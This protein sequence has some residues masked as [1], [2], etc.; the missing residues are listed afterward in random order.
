ESDVPLASLLSGGIDS[1]LVSVAAQRALHGELRTF[2]V[3]FSHKDYD[4]TWAAEMVAKHIGSRHES[5]D[6]NQIQGSCDH[7]T[8]LLSHAAQPFADTSL[9]AV[10]AICRLMRQHVTVA[11][12][13]DGGDEAFGGYDIYWRLARIACWQRL[14]AFC[15]M[16]A[17][18]ALRPLSWT[19]IST[20]YL[21]KR[22]RYLASAD[23]TAVV[24]SLLSLL[25][26]QEH[27]HLF[28]NTG[29]LPV[30]RLFER[31]WEHN[32]PNRLGGIERLCAH[33]TE[34]NIRLTLANDFLFKVDTASMMES[35]EIRVPMLD[36]DLFA[37]GLSLPRYL[38]V[39]GR[40]CKRTLRAVAARRLPPQ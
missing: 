25:G 19:G 28:V 3:R 17:S 16:S 10:N 27:Q 40:T 5:L 37:F 32:V 20:T 22:M 21:S 31:Q 2:N 14:P 1:S 30:R 39:D 24:Q 29:V 13:G 34:A 33:A 15:L 35:L 7:I 11:I 38:K 18:L 23:D 8:R 26:E 12:A 6:M 4:E 36:E 9:F